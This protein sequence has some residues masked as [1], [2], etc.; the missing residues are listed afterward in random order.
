MLPKSC[1]DEINDVAQRSIEV[2]RHNLVAKQVKI[3]Q[4]PESFWQMIAVRLIEGRLPLENNP[5]VPIGRYA[6]AWPGA[7]EYL[8]ER[9]NQGIEFERDGELEKA[10][11]IYE[12]SVADSFF[13]THPYDRLRIIYIKWK[14]YKDAVRVC[15]LYLALPDRQ[16]GQ[17]K[18]SFKRHLEKLS[19]TIMQKGL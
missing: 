7:E 8:V 6:F 15:Q 10:I 19:I 18:N 1:V 14:W 13:G 9:N 12:L 11:E 5:L 4:H 3:S 2:W 16:Q 17:N